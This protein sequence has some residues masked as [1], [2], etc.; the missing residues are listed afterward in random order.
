MFY[1]AM[2]DT[3]GTGPIEAPRNIAL[4]ANGQEFVFQQPRDVDELADCCDACW[5]EVFRR[6]RHR[7]QRAVDAGAG[8]RVVVNAGDRARRLARR[9]HRRRHPTPTSCCPSYRITP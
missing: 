6:L 5:A 7:W 9:R 8:S 4:D 2:T 3:C 1:G